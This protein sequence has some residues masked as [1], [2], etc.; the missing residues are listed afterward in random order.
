[1]WNY[2]GSRLF[3]DNHEMVLFQ[4]IGEEWHDQAPVGPDTE[5]ALIQTPYKIKGSMVKEGLGVCLWW[6]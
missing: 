4:V 3:Y 6:Q 2:D 1:V 5:E